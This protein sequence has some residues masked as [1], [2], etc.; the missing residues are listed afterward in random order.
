MNSFARRSGGVRIS[1]LLLQAQEKGLQLAKAGEV[2]TQPDVPQADSQMS[3]KTSGPRTFF[4][5]QTL[6]L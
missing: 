3:P 4:R 1:V 6:R 2:P 5:P